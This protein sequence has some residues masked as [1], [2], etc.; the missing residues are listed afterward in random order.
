MDGLLYIQDPLI[1]LFGLVY[2]QKI[3]PDQW[4]VAK[5]IPVHKKGSKS[6]IENYRPVANLCSASKIFERLILNRI[7]QLEQMGNVVESLFL[8]F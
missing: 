3:I 2:E 7:L 5:I 4:H 1:K 8:G 6:M